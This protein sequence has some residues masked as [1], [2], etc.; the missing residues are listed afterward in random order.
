MKVGYLLSFVNGYIY[1][2][3]SPIQ[4]EYSPKFQQEKISDLKMDK[5]FEERKN[6]LR[7]FCQVKEI[8]YCLAR[9]VILIQ[10]KYPNAARKTWSQRPRHI[11]VADTELGLLGCAP[12]KAGSSTWKAWWWYHM[13]PGTCLYIN[14]VH[15]FVRVIYL[16]D[17]F[18]QIQVTKEVFL[19]IKRPFQRYQ[20]NKERNC[21]R[22]PKR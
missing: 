16:S 17:I 1:H 6:Q 12:L 13:T 18:F 20:Q 3:N 9:V 15:P 10:K 4:M 11:Y 22:H 21:S 19:D 7:T 2:D 8:Q 14:F 5:I